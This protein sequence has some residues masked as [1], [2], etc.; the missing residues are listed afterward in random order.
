MFIIFPRLAK[1]DLRSELE[2]GVKIN[3][4]P[5]GEILNDGIPTILS[6]VRFSFKQTIKQAV[7]KVLI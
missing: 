1:V 6:L 3:L 7:H 4:S 2:G 5:R